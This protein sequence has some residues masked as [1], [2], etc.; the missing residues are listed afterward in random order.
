MYP[1]ILLK[2]SFKI[3]FTEC[4]FS[5][6]ET[7]LKKAHLVADELTHI[8]DRFYKIDKSRN[9]RGTG[10]GLAIAKHLIELHDALVSVQSELERGTEIEI[11]L[12][13]ASPTS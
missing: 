11:K 5:S 8:W 9:G 2:S 1:A 7:L 4:S 10:L 6:V 12:P 3:Q 13:L